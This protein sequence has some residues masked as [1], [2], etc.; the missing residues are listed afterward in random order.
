MRM[1]LSE[2]SNPIK[3]LAVIG[4]LISPWFLTQVGIA[5]LAPDKE[6]ETMPSCELDSGNC[7]HLGGGET[8]RMDS[9]MA[10]TVEL[11]S[12]IVWDKLLDYIED[13]GGEILVEITSQSSYYVHFVEKTPFWKFPDD[14]VISITDFSDSC[15]IEMHSHSRLG[16]GDIGVNPDRLN[17]IHETL[18]N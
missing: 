10:T 16:R 8:Y 12:S 17:A 4:L 15:V 2:A 9:S 11:N 7:A 3:L 1:P 6:I 13:N 14:I 18:F 5:I